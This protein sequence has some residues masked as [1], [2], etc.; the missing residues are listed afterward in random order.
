MATTTT[1]TAAETAAEAAKH[2]V[3]LD[4]IRNFL[5][6]TFLHTPQTR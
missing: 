3:E 5:R 4:D 6:T 1:T 2:E